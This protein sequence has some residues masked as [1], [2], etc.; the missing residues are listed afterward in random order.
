MFITKKHMS[1]RTVL[2]GMGAAISLPLLESMLPAA[3][4]ERQSALSAST[5]TRLA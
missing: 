4:P 1:R 5:R 3:V 2:Q